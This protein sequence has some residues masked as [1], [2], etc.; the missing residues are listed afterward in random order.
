MYISGEVM[1][2]LHKSGLGRPRK[3][4]IVFAWF[5]FTEPTVDVEERVVIITNTHSLTDT[6]GKHRML[7]K[8]VLLDDQFIDMGNSSLNLLVLAINGSIS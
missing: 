4:A 8:P 3:I 5:I 7:T 2:F 1:R 6:T